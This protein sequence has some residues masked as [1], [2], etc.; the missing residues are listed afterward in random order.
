MCLNGEDKDVI[1][2]QISFLMIGIFDD[3]GTHITG[4]WFLRRVQMDRETVN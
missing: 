4:F 2:D 3:I 1:T